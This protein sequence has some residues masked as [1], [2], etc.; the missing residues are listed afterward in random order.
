MIQVICETDPTEN[1]VSAYRYFVSIIN[2]SFVSATL[3]IRYVRN[4]LL[5]FFFFCYL[6]DH[7]FLF[8]ESTLCRSGG[9]RWADHTASGC[10]GTSAWTGAGTTQRAEGSGDGGGA[11]SKT[12]WSE[13]A[14]VTVGHV[15]KRLGLRYEMVHSWIR[16]VCSS[17]NQLMYDAM[18]V[19]F[20][21][22]HRFRYRWIYLSYIPRYRGI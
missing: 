8:T 4:I 9:R 3:N 15:G 22:L 21:Y 18:L 12:V 11:K 16:S 2:L 10:G 7:L 20:L 5:H 14:E 1:P 13:E 6:C 17:V 19:D